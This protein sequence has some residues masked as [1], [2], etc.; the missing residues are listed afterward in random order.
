MYEG[1]IS[2]GRATAYLTWGVVALLL[3]AAWVVNFAVGP[4]MAQLLGYS[5]CVGSAVAAVAHIRWIAQR[6]CRFVTASMADS[7]R[8]GGEYPIHSVH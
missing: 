5:A 4:Q 3:A 6:A 1:T 2:V 7:S 8:P